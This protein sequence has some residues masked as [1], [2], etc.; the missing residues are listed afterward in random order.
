MKVHTKTHLCRDEIEVA[1]FLLDGDIELV[2]VKPVAFYHD[3]TLYR[4]QV[5][6]K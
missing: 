4:F 2:E 1:Q 3:G 6:Y 5:R